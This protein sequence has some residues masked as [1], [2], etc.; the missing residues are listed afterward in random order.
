[1][2]K[3]RII[4]RVLVTLTTL[5]ALLTMVGLLKPFHWSGDLV[6][7]VMDYLFG[8]LLLVLLGFLL[9]K[10]WRWATAATL[11][12]VLNG[13]GLVNYR[14][15]ASPLSQDTITVALSEPTI[16]LMVYNIYHQNQDLAAVMAEIRKYDP[17]LLFLMEYSDAIQAQIESELSDYPHQLIRTSRQ[18]MGLALLSRFPLER[19]EIHR[20]NKTRIPVF[21]AV[22]NV[23]GNSFTFVGGHA[24]PPQPRWGQLHRD[25]VASIARVAGQIASQSTHPL[26][27]AGDFNAS[28]WSYAMQD[29]SQ[30]A[31]VANILRPFNLTKTSSPVWLLG[32]PIDHVLL[33]DEWV[34]TAIEYGD[35]GGSDHRPIV[36]DLR[37]D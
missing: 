30:Q 17:D 26:I 8:A 5:F 18:T 2:S 31:N 14:A 35:K 1:M 11:L 22:I 36:V 24:W 4:Y 29:L 21:E 15:T 33:S 19:T 12:L 13:V 37:F 27:V 9:L 10:R 6:A 28:Q 25:Q 32:L 20:S 7:L 3:K 34:V 16:R 23:D